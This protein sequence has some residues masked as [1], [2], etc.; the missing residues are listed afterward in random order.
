MRC[1]AEIA[2]QGGVDILICNAGIYYLP[3]LEIVHGVE[4]HFA[5]NHLGHFTLVSRLWQDGTLSPRCRVVI[6]ASGAHANVDT[7]DFEGLTQPDLYDP[8]LAYSQ[9]KLANGVFSMEL[10]R[11]FLG[12]AMTSN[13]VSPMW[14]M[15][16]TMRQLLRR[17]GRSQ[18]VDSDAAKTP[19]Q[20]AGT[21]CYVATAPELAGVTGRYF[22]DTALAEPA[23][24]MRDE[25][26]GAELWAFSERLVDAI[27]DE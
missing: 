10:S 8:D 16:E 27:L 6:V 22:R 15:T 24:Q 23:P 9:S 12:T 4:K 13:V 25:A 11:R 14:V 18:E 3:E 26:L 7:I 2:E 21:T 20:G 5:V 1:A 19:Q 17:S